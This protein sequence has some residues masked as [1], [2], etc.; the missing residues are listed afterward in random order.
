LF[1]RTKEKGEEEK[2]GD[3]STAN[4]TRPY[5]FSF[6]WEQ[7][8]ETDLCSVAAKNQ[9]SNQPQEKTERELMLVERGKGEK[10][11]RTSSQRWLWAWKTL[12]L[13][14]RGQIR[15]WP[16]PPEGLIFVGHPTLLQ[17]Y[18][19]KDSKKKKKVSLSEVRRLCFADNRV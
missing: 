15:A 7:G 10:K 6:E 2:R 19:S 17:L 18:Q 16:S 14:Q 3:D 8:Q 5:F 4:I 1:A 11:G 12:P 13:L 9:P